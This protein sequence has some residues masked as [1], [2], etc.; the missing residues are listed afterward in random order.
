MGEVEETR[1]YVLSACLE[2]FQVLCIEKLRLVNIEFARS[3]VVPLKYSVTEVDG[4]RL[5]K[6]D[7]I[8]GLSKESESVKSW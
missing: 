3:S 4:R 5:L 8:E 1:R 2:F 7:A 6:R